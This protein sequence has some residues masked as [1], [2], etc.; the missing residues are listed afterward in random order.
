MASVVSASGLGKAYKLGSTASYG[1]I[2]ESLSQGARALLSPGRTRPAADVLWALREAS[3]EIDQGEVVGLVGPNGAGKSTLLKL[4]ARI[5]PPSE[6]SA[7]IR[8][9]VGA[10]L[11]VGTGFHQELTGRENVLLSGAILGMRRPEILEKFDAIVEFAELERFIDTP[12]KRYSS[13]MG[14]RLAFAVAAFLEPEILLVD[15]VLAVGDLRFREKCLGRIGEVSRE[16]GRTIVF[17]SHDLN[18]IL[19][20][21]Q[22][23]L[24][25]QRGTIH[26]DGPVEEVVAEYEAGRTVTETANGWHQRQG[27]AVA[28]DLLTG[29]RIDGQNGRAP[30]Q[31]EELTI[32][33]STAPNWSK[34]RYSLQLR[35]LDW[36]HRPVGF[37]SSAILHDAYFEPGETARCVIG[38]LP[39]AT[40]R[41]FL[42][43]AA[44][45]PGGEGVDRWPEEIAFRIARLGSFGPAALFNPTEFSGVVI[46]THFWTV[47]DEGSSD[48]SK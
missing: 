11:E 42:E 35:V 20:T 27:R 3:F 33:V 14:V 6:G 19:A 25:V 7:T 4:L 12:V 15:E 31:G 29:V 23:A 21:C 37:M 9:R 32:T 34:G 18:S 17:V 5:T 26:R 38:D 46:P 28:T 1:R 41:Y 16:D 13:G 43:I 48:G 8:G 44:F 47:I 2:T 24:L 22:R 36:R 30:A 10:L 39:L 40:G 45:L